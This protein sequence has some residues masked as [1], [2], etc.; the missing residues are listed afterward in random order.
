LSNTAAPVAGGPLADSD[1]LSSASFP[2]QRLFR[3]AWPALGAL[4]PHFAPALSC[5]ARRARRWGRC[6]GSFCATANG[7]AAGSVPNVAR[8]GEAGVDRGIRRRFRDGDPDS[9]RLVY[10]AYG[11]LVYAVAHRVLRDVGLA[12]EA[13]QQTL[14]LTL[15]LPTGTRT[16]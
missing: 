14:R 12:E 15:V 6:L 3:V 11:R 2:E 7:D 5:A 1:H 9:V 10:R 16:K 13:T 4:S 8:P